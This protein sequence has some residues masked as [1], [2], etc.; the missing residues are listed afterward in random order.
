MLASS[1]RFIPS[2]SSVASF[3]FSGKVDYYE[4]IH[5]QAIAAALG[6]ESLN[7]K[8]FNF[9]PSVAPMDVD[10]DSSSGITTLSS[11]SAQKKVSSNDLTL[12]NSEHYESRFCPSIG[13]LDTASRVKRKHDRVLSHVPYRM[14]T[15]C[16]LANDFYCTLLAWSIKTGHVAVGLRSQVCIW[17]E[18]DGANILDLPEGY[19]AVT[20]LAFSVDN[21]LA[22]GRR[23]GS[24]MFY[25][26]DRDELKAVY[27]HVDGSL[28]SMIWLP[29]SSESLFVGD[30]IGSV[31][32]LKIC[33]D[34]GIFVWKTHTIKVHTQQI[35]GIAISQN[36]TQMAI[37]GN[38]NLVT[39]WDITDVDDPVLQF[40]MAHRAAVKALA[41]CPWNPGLLA[42]GGGTHDRTVRFWHT[43][44]GAL[45]SAH[46]VKGQIT[47]IIWSR[48][49]R[50]LAVTFGFGDHES[51]V[52]IGVY[53]YH[54]F[55]PLIRIPAVI[56]T[57][58]LTAA[59]SPDG[60]KIC[61]IANDDTV[62]FYEI[63]GN[64]GGKIA[65]A[66]E[67]LFQSDIIDMIE[68]IDKER[69]VIR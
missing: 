56:G 37:G 52:L 45:L 66:S 28:C 41:F 57:R 60:S 46:N 1:D 65:T 10:E 62:R 12:I 15:A 43:H 22:I 34:N 47:S 3:H 18:P 61:L 20:C 39:L 6:F 4:D 14:L 49:L 48:H 19:S 44:S 42:T 11:K 2:N 13:R 17:S 5:Q 40:R 30:D 36:L 26:L 63:W 58:V 9:A 51:P 55:K 69:E 59:E 33:I 54:N 38:D 67:G 53:N 16:G 23:D 32:H 68:G 24:I 64:N 31:I 8:V 21:I 35:C 7:A 29:G 25:D 50:Q 27:I